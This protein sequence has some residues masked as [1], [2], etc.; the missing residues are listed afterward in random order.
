MDVKK[1]NLVA[2]DLDGTLVDSVDDLVNAVN[3]TLG[4]LGLSALSSGEIKG[5]VGD[6]I[7][8]LI[9]RSL[10]D[11]HREREEKALDMF[12]S[13]YDEHLLD[14]T[15]LYQGV[16]GVLHH[17]RNT[18]KV[19]ITNKRQYFAEKI[20]KSLGIADHFLEI[21]GMGARKYT[22]P[23]RRLIDEFMERYGAGADETLVVGDGINDIMLAKNAGIVSCALLNGLT[24]RERLLELCPDYS[25]EE[26][27]ELKR[28]FR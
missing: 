2:F 6:G 28:Y 25:C 4:E 19:I 15:K 23:D 7:R 12:I 20:V 27:A 3:H 17:F 18:S 1:V 16:A 5:F 13:Y 11:E 8:Q 9:A 21:V 10:G 14:N 22:K 26:I 24:E